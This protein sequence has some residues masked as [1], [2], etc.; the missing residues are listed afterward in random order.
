V[1]NRSVEDL[2]LLNQRTLSEKQVSFVVKETLKG[3]Y[4]LHS[5]Q[6]IHRDVKAANIL[7]TDKGSVKLGSKRKLF[8]F[9][10]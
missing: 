6:I 7:L 9:I 4:Y 8:Y 5:N 10:T 2:M 3:L 1:I